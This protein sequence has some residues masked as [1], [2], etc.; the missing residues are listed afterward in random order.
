MPDLRQLPPTP[1]RTIWWIIA[2]SLA[3]RAGFAAILPL[4]TDEAYALAVGRS[5]SLSFFDHPPLGFW[6]PA[7]A[8]WLTGSNAP[9]IL[10]LPSLLFGTVALWGLYLCG[11]A[12]GGARA[13]NWTASLGAVAPMLAFSGT[14]ILPDAPLYAGLALTL[15]ALIRLAQG[16]TQGYRYW[17][18]GGISLAVA[19]ASKYQAGL[20]PI[21]LLIWMLTSR[22]GRL[23]FAQAGFY[24]AVGLALLG[25]LPVLLWNIGHDW[26]SFGFHAGRAG[27]GFSP[28]NVGLM[29]LGQA[30]YL[31]PPVL[32]WAVLALTDRRV[33]QDPVLR[34]VAMIGLGPILMFNAIY[35]VSEKSLAHWTMAGWIMILPLI[36]LRITA[37]RSA[38]RWLLATGAPLYAA[39]LILTVH[40]ATGFL[41]FG[42]PPPKWDRTA[43][44]IPMAPTRAAI[45]Q[46]GVLDRADFV[47]ARNWIT[48][49]HIAAALGPAPPMRVL[50]A[51][52][53][54]FAYMAQPKGQGILFAISTI[55]QA[56]KAAQDLLTFARKLDAQATLLPTIQVPRGWED[57]FI[58]IP[59]TVSL[60]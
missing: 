47:A 5:F 41:A 7:V 36:A 43:P 51:D 40:L 1:N 39:G 60:P 11:S 13:G 18:L 9:F 32:V 44:L 56:D 34:L 28:A 48:A 27:S 50:S 58:L 12:L 22:A 45:L 20:L 24:L 49:G 26:A 2:L 38:S 17:L 54:H 57:Y 25:L 8:E 52:Q 3:A 31:L 6:A 15:Y 19:L 55:D 37:P 53:H 14:M 29:A 33:W 46:S 35:L 23:W 21:T 10:R 30:L 16:Q 4:G 59:V 42:A